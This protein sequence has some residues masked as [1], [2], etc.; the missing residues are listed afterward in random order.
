MKTTISLLRIYEDWLS[1]RVDVGKLQWSLI[2]CFNLLDWL[3]WLDYN[4]LYVFGKILHQQEY[5]FLRK[6]LE[7]GLSKHQ[8]SNL[9]NSQEALRNIS[10]L[11]GIEKFRGVCNGKIQSDFYDD[12]QDIPDPSAL[13]SRL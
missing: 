9:F 6:G 8:I 13:D 7:A 2:S 10:P 11:T 5:K 3:D 12:C 1:E 4:N